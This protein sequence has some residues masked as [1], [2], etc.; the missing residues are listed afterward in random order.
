MTQLSD[1]ANH[2]Q[3]SPITQLIAVYEHGILNLW[4]R[5]SELED[6]GFKLNRRWVTHVNRHDNATRYMVYSMPLTRHNMK[7]AKRLYGAKEK[8]K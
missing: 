1:L 8:C 3:K 5:A 7:L 2:L 6:L 4:K